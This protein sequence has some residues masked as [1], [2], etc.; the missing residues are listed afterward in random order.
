MSTAGLPGSKRVV[1][2]MTER[3]DSSAASHDTHTHTATCE[4]VKR[5]A[6]RR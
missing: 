5:A 1:S 3:A 2:A 4:Q 6:T